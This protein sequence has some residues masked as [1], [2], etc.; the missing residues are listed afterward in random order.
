M[1]QQQSPFLLDG[2]D[3]HGPI[4]AGTGED[5][6]T[7]IAMFFG[8]GAEE[9]VDLHGATTGRGQL[10]E[11][12]GVVA[13]NQAFGRWNHIDMIG[14]HGNALI[15]LQHGHC[16]IGLEQLSQNTLMFR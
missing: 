9:A 6:R 15:D 14:L 16:G 4:T 7:A 10:L 5:D 8:Q 1:N 13:D 3:A 12:E 11:I 2:L